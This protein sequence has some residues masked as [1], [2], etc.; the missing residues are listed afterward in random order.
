VEKRRVKEGQ[1]ARDQIRKSGSE[2][3]GKKERSNKGRIQYRW[4]L[5]HL[6]RIKLQGELEG[7]EK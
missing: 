1:C 6:T 5:L 4:K 2:M 7:E 3:V